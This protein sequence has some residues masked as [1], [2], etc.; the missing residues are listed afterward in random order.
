R[1]PRRSAEIKSW[2]AGKSLTGTRT[3]R[4]AA[5]A[6]TPPCVSGDH[7]RP[8]VFRPAPSPVGERLSQVANGEPEQRPHVFREARNTAREGACAPRSRT[9][10][11]TFKPRGPPVVSPHLLIPSDHAA[12]SKHT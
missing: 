2:S 3:P 12:K 9:R 7:T 5:C 4:I 11:L 1:R 10:L 8:R 6:A